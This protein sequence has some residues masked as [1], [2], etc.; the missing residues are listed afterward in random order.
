MSIEKNLSQAL[1][2]DHEPSKSKEVVEYEEVVHG[3]NDQDED[4]RLAREVLRNLIKK[5][6]A[7]IDDI[8]D[9]AKQ[10]E[11]A[12]GFE[13]MSTLIKTVTDTTKELYGLQ[14]ITK[15]LKGPDPDTDPRSKSMDT[16]NINVEQAVFVGSA[17]ELLSQI[18]KKKEN[19]EN[20]VQLSEQSQLTK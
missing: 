11:S 18:K 6:N 4:Y 2:I 3:P 15:D 9:I 5:G 20:T 14:K 19:G 17:A 7:A 13:V 12:R 1:D 16:G 8:N 10:N